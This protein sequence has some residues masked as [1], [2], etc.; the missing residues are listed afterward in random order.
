MAELEHWEER[1]RK[2]ETPWDTGH[3]STELQRVVR[4]EKIKPC[5]AIELGCGTGTNAVWLAQQG[6]DVT[7]VDLSSLAIDQAKARAAQAGVSVHFVAGDLLDPPEVGGPFDFFFDR[8]CYHVVR[9]IDVQLFLQTLANITQ[10]G[11]RGLVLT[12]NAKEPRDP[13]PPVVQETELRTELGRIFNIV[14]LREFRFDQSD[15]IGVRFLGWSCFA[16]R[17]DGP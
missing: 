14:W 8:G 12:G 17:R 1:Y 9:R 16:E 6:F 5:R 4:E 7:A 10:P 2:G 15:Q 11:T 3:P 13:G